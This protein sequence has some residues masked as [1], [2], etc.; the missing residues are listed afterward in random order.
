M[1]EELISEA[2]LPLDSAGLRLRRAREASGKTLGAIAGQTRI[3]ERLLL[4]LEEGNYAALP[5]RAY[6]VGFS[7]SY[8]RLVG[9]NEAEIV[10]AVRTELADAEPESE[11]R[12]V[13]TFEPGDPARVPGA[14]LAWI[15]ALMALV[16][17]AGLAVAWR[18]YYAPAESLPS[19]VAD[20]APANSAGAVPAPALAPAAPTGGAVVFTAQQDAVWIKFYDA[21]G[22]QLMQK[23]MALGESYTVPADAAGPRAWTARPDA[24]AITV[25]GKPVPPLSPV[26]I[27][28]KD[29]EV[30]AAALLARPVA[31]VA[32]PG[33]ATEAQSIQPA[34]PQPAQQPR[35]QARHTNTGPSVR[36]AQVPPG[37]ALAEPV[38]ASPQA[39]VQIVSPSV[40]APSTVTQ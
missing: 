26:Q 39:A 7:R 15:A 28:M 14:R 11:R 18:S 35:R 9:L 30:S 4:A 24:F 6:A 20:A 10:E 36:A 29:V 32:Q 34:A 5:A 38:Q 37:P 31:A 16:F 12:P 17:V 3:P 1:V 27:T 19:L 8:A 22:A 21:A 23:Q 25:G 40:A 2:E 33:P 13:N